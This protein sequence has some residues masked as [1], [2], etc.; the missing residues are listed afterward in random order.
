MIR[1]R[2]TALPLNSV[3]TL[4]LRPLTVF[5]DNG[6]PNTDDISAAVWP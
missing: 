5:T 2:A 4:A 6:S 3:K 1:E